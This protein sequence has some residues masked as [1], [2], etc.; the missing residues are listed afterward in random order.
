MLSDTVSFKNQLLNSVILLIIVIQ[1]TK[2]YVIS[3]I[4][5]HITP[6][7]KGELPPLYTICITTKK[8]LTEITDLGG[9]KLKLVLGASATPRIAS[10][11]RR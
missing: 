7:P 3:L 1:V 4:Y 9:M 5:Q 10:L 11:L 6:P 8:Y 2:E